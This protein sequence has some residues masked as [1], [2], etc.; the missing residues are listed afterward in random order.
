M[1][2]SRQNTNF[3]RMFDCCTI[4][5]FCAQ[6]FSTQSKIA[7]I[8]LSSCSFRLLPSREHIKNIKLIFFVLSASVLD[9][10]KLISHAYERRKFCFLHCLK[11]VRMK[12]EM[13]KKSIEKWWTENSI[14]IIG[15]VFLADSLKI[16]K[17]VG[18]YWKRWENYSDFILFIVH[19]VTASEKYTIFPTFS[20]NLNSFF[21]CFVLCFTMIWQWETFGTLFLWIL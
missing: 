21:I 1:Y 20:L 17:T 3:I 18:K 5:E 19:V 9:D 13:K 7:T 14:S 6:H 12:F 15:E 10:W 2:N 8:F 4:L 16:G 11:I